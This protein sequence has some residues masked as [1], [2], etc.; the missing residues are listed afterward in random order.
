MQGADIFVESLLKEGVDTILVTLVERF[1][2]SMMPS[3]VAGFGMY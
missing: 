1:C 2:R 3:T